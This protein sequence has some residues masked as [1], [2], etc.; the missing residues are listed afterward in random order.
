MKWKDLPKK[1]SFLDPIIKSE[2]RKM[3]PSAYSTHSNWGSD[4]QNTHVQGHSKKGVFFPRERPMFTKD[5]MHEET[6]KGIP[7]PGT[8][9]I[10]KQDKFKLGRSSMSE[11]H[12]YNIDSAVW[13]AK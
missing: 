6:R 1:T 9:E 2:K 10:P 11:K 13:H 3:A 5:K 8:Y 7:A 4:M 12:S